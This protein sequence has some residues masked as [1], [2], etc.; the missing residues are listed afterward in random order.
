MNAFG[1][2]RLFP[3]VNFFLIHPVYGLK[4]QPGYSTYP[5]YVK[6]WREAMT[7]A[8]HIA[9]DKAGN[10][11]RSGKNQYS[12]KAKSAVENYDAIGKIQFTKSCV[13]SMMTF[14]CTSSFPR[15]V[16]GRSELFTETCCSL[17]L[18]SP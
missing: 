14:P 4:P 13:K 3:T 1:I 17:V 16:R 15:T 11:A 9:S 18:T 10:N 5:E 7:V 6:K 2:S 12:K 8:Y